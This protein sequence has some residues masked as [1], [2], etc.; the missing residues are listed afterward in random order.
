MQQTIEVE[1]REFLESALGQEIAPDEDYFAKGIVDSLFALELVTFLEHRFE[2]EIDVEDLSL[3]HFR[4]AVNV[5]EFVRKKTAS[6]TAE[7]PRGGSH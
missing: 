2:F 1:I 7:V 4:T 5:A 3:D 6:P